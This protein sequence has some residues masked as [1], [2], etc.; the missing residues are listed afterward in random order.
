MR[1][2]DSNA[3]SGHAEGLIDA[4]KAVSLNELSI[5]DTVWVDSPCYAPSRCAAGPTQKATPLGATYLFRKLQAGALDMARLAAPGASEE[6]RDLPWRTVSGTATASTDSAIRQGKG[7]LAQVI[8]AGLASG[9]RFALAAAPGS[10]RTTVL[11]DVVH[12]LLRRQTAPRERDDEP[13]VWQLPLFFHARD[14]QATGV[15]RTLERTVAQ[16]YGLALPLDVLVP[17][18]RLGFFV[19]VID[20]IEDWGN[21]DRLS[22]SDPLVAEF[23][24]LVGPKAP[25]L[26]SVDSRCVYY[27]IFD[28]DRVTGLGERMRDAGD[29]ELVELA[30]FVGRNGDEPY[31]DAFLRQ[32]R[33]LATLRAGKHAGAE[34]PASANVGAADDPVERALGWHIEDWVGKPDPYGQLTPERRREL[35]HQLALEQFRTATSSLPF[36]RVMD[37]VY[38]SISFELRDT[39]H[40]NASLSEIFGSDLFTGDEER[41]FTFKS[42]LIWETALVDLLARTAARHG[43]GEDFLKILQQ[44]LLVERAS[45]AFWLHRD[46]RR[47]TRRFYGRIARILSYDD[48]LL[49]DDRSSDPARNTLVGLIRLLVAFDRLSDKKPPL[50]MPLGVSLAGAALHDIDFSELDLSGWNFND[51]V[52][53]APQ[54]VNSVLEDCSFRN[55]YI[56]A[57]LFEPRET[58]GVCNFINARLPGVRFSL[59]AF[60]DLPLSRADLSGSMVEYRQKGLTS[61]EWIRLKAEVDKAVR[62][63]TIIVMRGNTWERL[64]SSGFD[65][66]LAA[67]LVVVPSVRLLADR[68][69]VAL[70]QKG[71]LLTITGVTLE[72]KNKTKKGSK[73]KEPTENEK[74]VRSTSISLPGGDPRFV[75]EAPVIG[76]H[77]E[78]A[79]G[80]LAA[81]STGLYALF[82]HED[83][84]TWSK[85]RHLD[86]RI[87]TP[88]FAALLGDD[89]TLLAHG[90][91]GAFLLTADETVHTL[92]SPWTDVRLLALPDPNRHELVATTDNQLLTLTLNRDRKAHG[93]WTAR[94]G[95]RRRLDGVPARLTTDTEDVALAYE[96]NSVQMVS[97]R[98]G[99]ASRGHHL[100][101]FTTIHDIVFVRDRGFLYVIGSW[102]GDDEEKDD[103]ADDDQA[104]NKSRF[105][106][107]LLDSRTGELILYYDLDPAGFDEASL[108]TELIRFIQSQEHTPEARMTWEQWS[109]GQYDGSTEGGY[110]IVHRIKAPGVQ[111]TYCAEQDLTLEIRLVPEEPLKRLRPIYDV[112]GAVGQMPLR[113]E[114]Q[115]SDADGVGHAVPTDT[116]EVVE[117]GSDVLVRFPWYFQKPGDYT[118]APAAFLGPAM[119]VLEVPGRLPVRPNNPFEHGPGLNEGNAYLFV[120]HEEMLSRL[121]EDVRRNNVMVCGSRR[122]GKS[123]LLNML[124]PRLCNVVGGDIVAAR[125]SFDLVRKSGSG[126]GDSVGV[127]QALFAELSLNEEYQRIF[128]LPDPDSITD[129]VRAKNA[130]ANLCQQLREALGES[131]RLVLLADE[132]NKVTDF[133]DAA[134][135]LGALLNDYARSFRLVAFG[136]PGDFSQNVD[137]L[138]NS[139]FP[140]FLTQRRYLRPLSDQEITTLAT[141]PIQ[142]RYDVDPAALD[143]LI[144]RA[145]GR[146]FDAQVMLSKAL[147]RNIV[148]GRTVLRADDVVRAFH[149]DLVTIY[150]SYLMD[151]LKAAEA[152]CPNEIKDWKEELKADFWAGVRL[153]NNLSKA[154]SNAHKEILKYGFVRGDAGQYINLPP[155]ILAAWAGY[156][157]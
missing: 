28:R 72:N 77:T 31:R 88:D 14:V 81:N 70:D 133:D 42:Q 118:L 57:L 140:R 147:D 82:W 65:A 47:N 32:R 152:A 6:R 16:V 73:K 36:E 109:E 22:T 127:I 49:P 11:T 21:G 52:M 58:R 98:Y 141:D 138:S 13:M 121:I 99:W 131:A 76:T 100:T 148:E 5:P 111:K 64:P 87:G 153:I 142:G 12:A 54:F 151:V 48:A 46:I 123:S 105:G 130:V 10:G 139:G 128:T 24:R 61:P 34:V 119:Q 78:F 50:R 43:I 8:T 25:F 3:G 96:D 33:E 114:V 95:A 18:M 45:L 135:F 110:Y 145:V 122:Q 9:D 35:V 124:L 71:G 15:G 144:K 115:I 117:D 1:G 30:P 20:G 132:V 97:R 63:S 17:A 26:V 106:T 112:P 150:Q 91:D 107:C 66:D 74:K 93:G 53:R 67:G 75:T 38:A 62:S 146:P 7:R 80:F 60:E 113:V 84:A 149:T 143:E 39:F 134:E 125:V 94:I 68:F 126:R 85:P 83:R 108:T 92:G 29:V 69:I 103:G 104:G 136:V 27:T 101:S 86:A 137:T 129:N 44:G 120:G 37:L 155:A 157:E 156:T 19:P 40:I 51:T 90:P 154:D 55:A 56:Q 41:G 102:R 59:K 116:I 23:L 79:T 4:L 89:G 2:D